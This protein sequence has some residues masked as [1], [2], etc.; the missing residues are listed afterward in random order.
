MLAFRRSRAFVPAV[1]V[2]AGILI[3]FF[4]MQAR[5]SDDGDDGSVAATERATN[6]SPV[7]RADDASTRPG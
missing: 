6:C 7:A 3:G 2:M 5:G 4:V 1:L